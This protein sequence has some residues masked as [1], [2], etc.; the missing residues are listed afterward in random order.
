MG[1]KIITIFAG[2]GGVGKTTCAAATALYH[3]GAGRRTLVIS[4]DPTP[5]LADIFEKNGRGKIAV[6][7]DNLQMH[8]LGLPE[9]K[10]MWETR[11]GRE[12]YE[13][14][15]SFVDIDYPEFVDFMTSILPGLGD[16]F[17]LDYIRQLSLQDETEVIIWDTAPLGQTLALLETPTLLRQHLKMAPRIYSRLKVGSRSRRPVLEILKRWEELSAANVEFLRHEVKFCTVTIAEALA[18]NQLKG[19]FAEL[20]KYGLNQD[21]VIINNL[22]PMDG[23]PFLNSRAAQQKHYIERIREVTDGLPVVEVPLFPGE[24]KGLAILEK[25]AGYLYGKL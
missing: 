11:F 4:T 22:V 25:F 19:V 24:V 17:M 20:D 15:A 8:E 12:V 3:A 9:V 7:T 5:S 2:K 23:S 10:Q 21:K 14:F 6:V 16:E 13:V 1:K 18:V